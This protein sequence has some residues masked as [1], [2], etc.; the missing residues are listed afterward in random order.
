MR[1][2]DRSLIG[3]VGRGVVLCA[4][5]TSCQDRGMAMAKDQGWWQ[6]SWRAFG[7]QLI[8]IFA[9]VTFISRFVFGDSW[10]TSISRGVLWFVL[11]LIVFGA[12]RWWRRRRRCQQRS[13]VAR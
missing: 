7:V 4:R 10:S 1:P 9:A 12:M 13:G 5:W 11:W 6:S 3:Q 2:V 8:C